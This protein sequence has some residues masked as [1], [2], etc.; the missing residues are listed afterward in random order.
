MKAPIPSDEH[1]LNTLYN[2]LESPTNEQYWSNIITR[3]NRNTNI[4]RYGGKFWGASLLKTFGEISKPKRLT[5]VPTTCNRHTFRIGASSE[6]LGDLSGKVA[7]AINKEWNEYCNGWDQLD[8]DPQTPSNNPLLHRHYGYP[9]E[10]ERNLEKYYKE[11]STGMILI[12]GRELFDIYQSSLSLERLNTLLGSVNAYPY[13]IDSYSMKR[14]I[15][16]IHPQGFT[17]RS[18]M[19]H[20]IV[21]LE[22]FTPKVD[23]SFG[24]EL[25]KIARAKEL[26]FGICM[27]TSIK[28]QPLINFKEPYKVHMPESV[29][30]WISL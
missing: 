12:L 7:F 24:Y 14:Y 19:F 16:W 5:E 28:Y 4:D 26:V 1:I 15:D 8:I 2:S 23:I 30:R 27:E 17:T 6:A 21:P 9:D 29:N 22:C 10:L 25:R 13:I 11:Y 3:L 20:V 18:S